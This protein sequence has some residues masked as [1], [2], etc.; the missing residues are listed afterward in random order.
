MVQDV[1]EAEPGNYYHT[2]WNCLLCRAAAWQDEAMKHHLEQEHL[3][4]PVF[5]GFSSMYV[6]QPPA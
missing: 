4:S 2:H 6:L 1:A 3:L 5:I